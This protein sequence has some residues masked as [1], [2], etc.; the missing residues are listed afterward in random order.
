MRYDDF[1]YQFNQGLRPDA[2]P[3]SQDEFVRIT[4]RPVTELWTEYQEAIRAALSS[5]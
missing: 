3:W 2:Q 5:T 4:G 1:V